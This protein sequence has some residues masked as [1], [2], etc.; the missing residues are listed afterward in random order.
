MICMHE[1]LT[2]FCGST[3]ELTQSLI[4]WWLSNDQIG[5]EGHFMIN[6]TNGE[7]IALLDIG[8]RNLHATYSSHPK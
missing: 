3:I 6:E 2:Y 7:W 1:I 4:L 5:E 8:Q